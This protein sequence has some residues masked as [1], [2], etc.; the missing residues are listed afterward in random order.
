MMDRE[1][2]RPPIPLVRLDR[3]LVPSRH[4]ALTLARKAGRAM[5]REVTLMLLGVLMWLHGVLLLPLRLLALM[6]AAMGAGF[7]VYGTWADVITCV[8]FV[9]FCLGM[10]AG[11]RRVAV[12]CILSRERGLDQ[13]YR[14]HWR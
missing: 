3:A 7:A 8:V 1:R 9:M 5:S 2:G 6:S 14:G 11:L 13:P 4:A 10:M 12:L